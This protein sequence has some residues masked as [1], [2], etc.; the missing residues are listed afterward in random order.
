[1][2]ITNDIITNSMFLILVIAL[3]IYSFSRK[4]TLNGI[5][6]SIISVIYAFYMYGKWFK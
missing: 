1:M 4:K 5:A 2:K 3:T 6:F